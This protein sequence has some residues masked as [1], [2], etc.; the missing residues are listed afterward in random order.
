MQ[1][2]L[3]IGKLN[4]RIK[5]EEHIW[6][7]IPLLCFQNDVSLKSALEVGYL[8]MTMNS[9]DIINKTKIYFCCKNI[10]SKTD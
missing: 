9:K 6:E 1:H 3:F 5:N 8:Q 7:Q 10:I 2:C 4:K